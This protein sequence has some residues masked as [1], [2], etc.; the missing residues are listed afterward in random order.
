MS[1]VLRAGGPRLRAAFVVLA[2]VV[3]AA[4]ATAAARPPQAQAIYCFY[5][6]IEGAGPSF[7]TPDGG[8]GAVYYSALYSRALDAYRDAGDEFGAMQPSGD[9]VNYDIGNGHDN[10][11]RIISGGRGLAVPTDDDFGGVGLIANEKFYADNRRPFGRLYLQLRN[12]T[13]APITF[14]LQWE[15]VTGAGDDT[16]VDRT[17]SGDGTAV[18]KDAWATSCDDPDGDGCVNIKGE[19]LRAPEFAHSWEVRRGKHESADEVD[20]SGD[21]LRV[22]FTDVTIGP[23]KTKSFAQ[24]LTMALNIRTARRAA[25]RAAKDPAGYGVFRGLSKKEKN[26]I[27]NW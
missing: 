7:W 10:D 2:A 23:G 6:A 25:A 27:V 13:A 11:C 16:N 22:E 20:F 17:S 14:D 5:P 3:L 4:L 1:D 12:P 19:R 15:T 9:E 24:L 21:T 8:G 18:A 26:R